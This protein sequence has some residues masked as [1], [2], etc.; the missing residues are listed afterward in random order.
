MEHEQIYL[1]SREKMLNDNLCLLVG[2]KQIAADW[3][4]V[5]G[6]RREGRM[7]C[8]LSAWWGEGRAC[9]FEGTGGQVALVHTYTVAIASGQVMVHILVQ[10][11][12]EALSEHIL[13]SRH[14][15]TANG[16]NVKMLTLGRRI[17]SWLWRQ[18]GNVKNR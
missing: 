4:K 8:G 15:G 6:W 13:Y 12:Q 16:H 17:F 1:N 18:T 11:V 7:T 5:V 2:V 14:S 3:L 9:T 10:F